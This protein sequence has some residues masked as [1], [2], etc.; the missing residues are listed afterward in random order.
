MDRFPES[1]Q[2]N[3]DNF[4]EVLNAFFSRSSSECLLFKGVC[5][6][7]R[8]VRLAELEHADALTHRNSIH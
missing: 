5:E 1:S 4:E 7:T 2:I 3:S 8:S 6:H